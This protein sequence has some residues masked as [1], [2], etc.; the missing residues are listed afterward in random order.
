MQIHTASFP[1]R[2]NTVHGK[3]R[4]FLTISSVYFSVIS[5]VSAKY[6]VHAPYRLREEKNLELRLITKKQARSSVHNDAVVMA[7]GMQRTRSGGMQVLFPDEDA[8]TGDAAKRPDVNSLNY[9]V[10]DSIDSTDEICWEQRSF[11]QEEVQNEGITEQNEGTE[12]MFQQRATVDSCDDAFQQ[13]YA[14]VMT[15]FYGR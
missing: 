12:R 7:S 15:R 13:M 1:T 3:V 10:V 2:T 8:A 14:C 6:Q 9:A 4:A 11:L 5:N